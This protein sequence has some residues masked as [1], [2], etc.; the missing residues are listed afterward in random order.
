MPR[1]L[2]RVEAV[3]LFANLINDT[4]DLST[5]RGGGL[6]ALFAVQQLKDQLPAL[7]LTPIATG[8]SVGLFEFDGDPEAVEKA[9]RQHFRDHTLEYPLDAP[10]KIGHLPLKHATFAVDVRPTSGSS[11]EDVQQLTA[12]N[13]WRQL[14][15]PTVSLDGLW[16]TGATD[17][18]HFDR[19]RPALVNVHMP[20]GQT[21]GGSASVA[22]RRRFGR[23][24]RQRFYRQELGREVNAEFT[25]DF[26]ELAAR[27]G[28]SDEQ[29]PTNT[30]DKLAVLYLDGNKFGHKQRDALKAGLTEYKEWSDALR[31]HHKAL[32]G[33]LITHATGDPAWQTAEGKLR[34]ETLLWGGDEIIWVVPAWKGWELAEWFFRQ[35]HEVQTEKLTYA[36]GLVFCHANAP[37]KNVVSLAK[38][39]GDAAKEVGGHRLAYEVLESFDDISGDF[40]AHRRKWLPAGFQTQK[41]VLN[42]HHL[43]T[44]RTPLRQVAAGDDF[45]TRQLYRLAHAWRAGDTAGVTA[46]QKRLHA[47]EV[48]QHLREIEATLG[49]TAWLH[50]L[51][52]LPYTPEVPQ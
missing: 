30:I 37:I 44:L 9:V 2:L 11:D 13:R 20:E 29:A 12:A 4:D 10:G 49:E 35:T 41:L 25:Q 36:G 51:N 1:F 43:T 50:L 5:R 15:E 21:V 45:P 40:D 3:N 39:L 18:C 23:G 17:P 16:G 14:S 31:N 33:E 38:R 46:A 27:D 28:L 42:P 47:C 19:V 34:L 8:A 32:L 6:L 7:N 26:R 52:M 22:D 48:G 24:S